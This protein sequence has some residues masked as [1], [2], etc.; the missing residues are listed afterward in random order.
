MSEEIE[1]AAL[2]VPRAILT[3]IL[4]NG[5]TGF[6]MVLAIL[7]CLGDIETVLV[8]FSP[9]ASKRLS[10]TAGTDVT[11]RLPFHSSL[12]RWSQIQSRRDG[13]GFHRSRPYLVCSH[14]VPRH[15]IAH[16]LVIC[17]RP[18]PSLPSIHK[19]GRI[20]TLIPRPCDDQLTPAGRWNRAP[21]SP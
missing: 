2:N 18:G 7:F 20:E 11:H 21:R 15:R 3:T 9:L 6:A 13:D 10:L 8:S 14:R 1:N 12:L 16:D 5:V 4:L 19:Q 17:P